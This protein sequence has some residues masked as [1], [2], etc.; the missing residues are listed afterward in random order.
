MGNITELVT[1]AGTAAVVAAVWVFLRS[2]AG[3]V[4]V[5]KLR[6]AAIEE[7][8]SLR[9]ALDNL[10]QVVES[11]G[12]SIEWLRSE[13]SNTRRELIEARTALTTKENR[14][15]K[16]NEKLRDRVAELEAQVKALEAALA[17]KT[18]APRKT[19]GETK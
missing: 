19:T 1:G 4:V 9:A 7:R 16:D 13:L 11:Q 17:K 6:R 14:L 2:E 18:R 5:S 8:A 10:S 12:E 3:K 15:A